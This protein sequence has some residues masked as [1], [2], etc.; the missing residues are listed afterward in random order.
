MIN[1]KSLYKN[2]CRLVKGKR[3]TCCIRPN[4]GYWCW[5]KGTRRAVSQKMKKKCCQT[6][7]YRG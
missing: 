2:K 3:E 4:K 1:T 6:R 5:S 7:R